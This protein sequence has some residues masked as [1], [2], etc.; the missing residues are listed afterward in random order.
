[1]EAPA[2]TSTAK[3][4]PVVGYTCRV[5]LPS[6][7]GAPVEVVLPKPVAP[8]AEVVSDDRGGAAMVYIHLG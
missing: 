4:P 1:M 7:R 6:L 8:G 3:F 5:I 2:W